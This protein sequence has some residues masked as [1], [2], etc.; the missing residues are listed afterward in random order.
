VSAAVAATDLSTYWITYDGLVVVD[1]GPP[2]S[3][4]SPHD[5]TSLTL[6]DVSSVAM[7]RLG[8]FGSAAAPTASIRRRCLTC[9]IIVHPAADPDGSDETHS[10]PAYDI[11]LPVK[12]PPLFKNTG[13]YNAVEINVQQ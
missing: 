1:E 3:S 7:T 11:F 6:V 13:Y 10:P 9:E 4:P 8:G 5:Q 12:I 2:R